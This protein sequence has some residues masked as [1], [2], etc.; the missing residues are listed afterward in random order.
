MCKNRDDDDSDK[1]GN[2]AANKLQTAMSA[3]PTESRHVASSRRSDSTAPATVLT[4]RNRLEDLLRSRSTKNRTA[5]GSKTAFTL[6][7][8]CAPL[9]GDPARTHQWS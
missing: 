9:A 1:A 5:G 8:A 6:R 7:P 3:K 4:M 2:L